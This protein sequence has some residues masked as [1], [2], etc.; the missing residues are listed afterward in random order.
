MLLNIFWSRT[1]N[2]MGLKWSQF[3]ALNEHQYSAVLQGL[4]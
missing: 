3:Q 1:D 4:Q 2:I